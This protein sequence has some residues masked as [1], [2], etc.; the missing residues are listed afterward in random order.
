MEELKYIITDE[1]PEDLA[2]D[3]VINK[4][5]RFLEEC[6]VDYKI[7]YI[8]AND[9]L[10]MMSTQSN[11]ESLKNRPEV[12]FIMPQIDTKV[13]IKRI[14]DKA[15]SDIELY[16]YG[17]LFDEDSEFY[18]PNLS[19]GRLGAPG[20]VASKEMPDNVSL[21]IELKRLVETSSFPDEDAMTKDA[22][23]KVVAY[24]CMAEFHIRKGYLDSGEQSALTFRELEKLFDIHLPNKPIN[25]ANI[26]I[27]HED[28]YIYIHSGNDSDKITIDPTEFEVPKDERF[29]IYVLNQDVIDKLQQEK[30]YIQHCEEI[31]E[32]LTDK[33]QTKPVLAFRWV[34]NIC[35]GDYMF[36]APAILMKLNE[37]DL[38]WILQFEGVY[39]YRNTDMSGLIS[40][41]KEL[42]LFIIKNKVL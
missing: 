8:V 28:C 7:Q 33:D 30:E 12:D 25:L 23:T 20:N 31:F 10:K 32:R 34:D 3:D 5:K 39:G 19:Y 9:G 13:R 26:L 24:T 40:L 2:Q 11:N 6:H 14:S 18:P 42:G 41:E 27:E 17:S 16:D 4:W 29:I 22:M 37:T 21:K 38:E 35:R 36:S 15:L 1:C